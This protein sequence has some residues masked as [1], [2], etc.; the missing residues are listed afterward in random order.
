ME[1]RKEINGR[2]VRWI[3]EKAER[4]YAEDIS[5]VL[6]YGSYV[7]NKQNELTKQAETITAQGSGRLLFSCSRPFS[8]Y[9]R[10]ATA[11]AR[12]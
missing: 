7:N 10:F 2:L 1:R 6:I 3:A 5:L 11:P 12:F 8:A 4:E 9:F